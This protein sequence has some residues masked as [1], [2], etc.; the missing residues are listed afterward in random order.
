[1]FDLAALSPAPAARLSNAVTD[2]VLSLELGGLLLVWLREGLGRDLKKRAL[3]LSYGTNLIGACAWT[4]TGV[5]VHLWEPLPQQ[6]TKLWQAFLLLG[7]ST[8]FL[9]PIVIRDAF[10]RASLAAQTAMAQDFAM[11]LLALAYTALVLSGVDLSAGHKL[12][13]L[14]VS[15]W[16]AI[17]GRSYD[18]QAHGIDFD[19]LSTM[20][21]ARADSNFV[22][23]VLFLTSNAFC[24]ILLLRA[25]T[26]AAEGSAARRLALGV[27]MMFLNC[28]LLAI[29]VAARWVSV[30]T[31]LDIFHVA[32]GVIIWFAFWDF[33][34]LLRGEGSEDKEK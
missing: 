25:Q 23:S 8:P 20:P 2:F 17:D 18:G 16:H 10:F 6:P 31:S 14:P 30:A 4:A 3:W 34:G 15:P 24:V 28:H 13:P 7:A 12:P 27:G 26:K 9:F 5:Y 19:L 32:Q 11:G 21:S 22:L 33:R 29:L 1:M